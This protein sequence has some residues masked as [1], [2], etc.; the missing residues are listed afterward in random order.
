M[1]VMARFGCG[2]SPGLC[3]QLTLPGYPC[4]PPIMGGP[5]LPEQQMVLE[6]HSLCQ[7][8]QDH[9][10]PASHKAMPS[11]QAEGSLA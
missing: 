8:C 10:P 2:V 11:L 1:R 5:H 4:S 9:R 3:V 7:L 6:N